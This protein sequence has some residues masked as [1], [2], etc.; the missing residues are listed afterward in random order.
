MGV[1]RPVA[2]QVP[3]SRVPDAAPDTPSQAS[4]TPT[5]ASSTEGAARNASP[6]PLSS[7]RASY[8]LKRAVAPSPRLGPPAGHLR[9]LPR[10][11]VGGGAGPASADATT[12]RAPHGGSVR[13]RAIPVV[14]TRAVDEVQVTRLPRAPRCALS[15]RVAP[16]VE[17]V[18]AAPLL[19]QAS[20]GGEVVPTSPD[21]PSE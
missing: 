13:T 11:V 16:A 8:P 14:A 10:V 3:T 5:R 7:V 17:L 1:I 20:R 4:V 19:G 6:E 15:A 21:L 2:I 12:G 9:N 18:T